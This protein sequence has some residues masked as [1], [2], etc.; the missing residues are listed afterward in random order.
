MEA[1]LD[2]DLHARRLVEN[3]VDVKLT[4][5]EIIVSTTIDDGGSFRKSR[6]HS[7]KWVE[8]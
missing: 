6:F 1:S 7:W 5:T 2:F 8:L 4:Y 3:P